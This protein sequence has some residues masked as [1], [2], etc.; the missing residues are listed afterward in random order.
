MLRES[1]TTAA[2]VA[3][4]ALVIAGLALSPVPWLALVVAGVI[5]LAGGFAFGADSADEPVKPVIQ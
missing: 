5:L 2:E 4:A 3:G 1:V